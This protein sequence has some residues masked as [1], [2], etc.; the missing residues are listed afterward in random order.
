MTTAEYLETPESVYP[1]ELA[2]GVL[3]VADSPTPIHQ[4]AVKAL[5]KA[6]DAHVEVNDLGEVWLSPLDVIL[7]HD[8]ALIVQP[9]LFFVSRERD[10]LV[11]GRIHGAPDLTIEVLSPSLRV[12]RMAE[13]IAWFARYGVRECW[14]VHQ[15]ERWVDVLTFDDG[16]VASRT[17]FTRVERIRSRV[18]PDFDRN[19]VS[20]LGY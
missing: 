13:H 7:D 19:L 12:G 15:V 11:G 14:F 2:F 6:L 8:E 18:L 20:I 4:R 5:L 17:R 9:D 16:N 1:T 10:L 3:R